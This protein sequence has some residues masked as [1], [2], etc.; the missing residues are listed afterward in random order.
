MDT[1]TRL[2]LSQPSD[3]VSNL[4]WLKVN[5]QLVLPES[6]LADFPEAKLFTAAVADGRIVLTPLTT[7]PAEA[8]DLRRQLAKQGVTETD[9]KAAIAWARGK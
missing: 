9:V 6:L 4:A 8:D 1:A 5:G 2:E 7:S 3:L